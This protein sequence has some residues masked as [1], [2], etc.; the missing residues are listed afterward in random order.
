MQLDWKELDHR[1]EKFVEY[2]VSTTSPDSARAHPVL[3]SKCQSLDDPEERLFFILLATHFDSPYLA[4]EFYDRLDWNKA[5]QT[6]EA[7]I[8]QICE[9]Y[10]YD[11]RF[12][13]KYAIGDHRRYFRCLPKNKKVDYS[14]EI[15]VSYRQVIGE[16]GSQAAFFG[17]GDGEVTFDT[18]Y[19]RM[20]KIAHFHPRL[21]RFDHLER[22]SRLHNFYV[23][24]DRFYAEVATGPLYGLTCLIFGKRL[25]KDSGITKRDIVQVFPKIWNGQV[26]RE[27]VIPKGADFNQVIARLE[28]WVIDHVKNHEALP[29]EKRRDK[30]FVFDVES[31]LCDWQKGKC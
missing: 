16:Y 1:L 25:S 31:C 27:Y 30:G 8:R 10:I 15:L 22:L 13:G 14:V 24:P 18:L 12:T 20:K 23:T 17:F 21:P 5:R 28:Q 9:E 29:P 26:G 4:D 11:R 6:S 7:T 2:F 3:Q 19:Q